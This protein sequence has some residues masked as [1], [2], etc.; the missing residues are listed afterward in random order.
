MYDERATLC[1]Y[2]LHIERAIDKHTRVIV[3]IDRDS[4]PFVRV[5]SRRGFARIFHISRRLDFPC[6]SI[7]DDIVRL[8]SVHCPLGIDET[9]L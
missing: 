1:A 6:I 5:G 3:E 4:L 7:V 2:L 8:H 9:Y